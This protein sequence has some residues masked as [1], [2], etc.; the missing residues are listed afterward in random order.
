MKRLA[1]IGGVILAALLVSGAIVLRHARAAEIKSGLP[2]GANV[3]EFRPRHE[4]GA[5]KGTMEC[6]ICKYEL[7]PAIQVWVN[8]DADRNVLA[9]AA[10][11]DKSMKVN[12]KKKL[13][14]FVVY[15]NFNHEPDQPLFSKIAALAVQNKLN[16]VALVVMPGDDRNP[17]SPIYINPDSR[18]RNTVY[19]YKKSIISAKF[20]N[21]VGDAKGLAALDNAINRV[22]E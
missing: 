2:I 20:V 21:L 11:L 1:A 12:A 15:A 14:A 13:K 7:N 10:N 22:L 8:G 3:V 6:P 4:S 19:V 17:A 16:D 18:I 5:D 9:I